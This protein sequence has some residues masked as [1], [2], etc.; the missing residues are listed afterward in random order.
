MKWQTP[1]VIIWRKTCAKNTSSWIDDLALKRDVFIPKP[2]GVQNPENCP[3]LG[4]FYRTRWFDPKALGCTKPKRPKTT[5]S[6]KQTESAW[7][8]AGPTELQPGSGVHRKNPSAAEVVY[9]QPAHLGQPRQPSGVLV[10]PPPRIDAQSRSTSVQSPVLYWDQSTGQWV[11]VPSV[12]P[13]LSP[14]H[15]TPEVTA[16]GSSLKSGEYDS[17]LNMSMWFSVFRVLL[18]RYRRRQLRRQPRPGSQVE[19]LIAQA[20]ALRR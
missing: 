7:A 13:G 14:F 9:G 5:G 15:S 18:V 17:P 12:A 4:T 1:T 16:G 11:R 10:Y 3:Q 6:A 2:W 8:E 20:T 19:V